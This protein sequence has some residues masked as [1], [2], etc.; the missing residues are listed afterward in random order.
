MRLSPT[1]RAAA[2][3][4]AIAVSALVL[5]TFVALAAA[6]ALAI[7]ILRDARS[8]RLPELRRS[9]PTVLNRG[10]PADLRIEPEPP[11]PALTVRQP[12]PPGIAIEPASGR[13]GLAAQLMPELRGPHRLAPF[14]VRMEG[15]ARLAARYGEPCPPVQVDVY[16]DL[17]SAR[18]LA[19]AV[20]RGRLRDPGLRAL[21]PLGLGTEFES[22]REYAPDDDV[23]RINWRATARLGRPMSNEFRLDQDR[24]VVC[25]VDAGRLMAAPLDV[26]S[27]LDASLDAVSAVALVADELGDRCGGLVFDS[28]IRERIAPRRSGGRGLI[29]ALHATRPS[30]EDSDYELAFRSLPGG[31]RALVLVFSDLID[32][33]AARA[34]IRAVPMLARRHAVA[35]V[36]PLDPDV[37]SAAHEPPTSPAGVYPMVAALEVLAARARATAEL[38]GAGATV[39]EAPASALAGAAVRGYVRS[40]LRATL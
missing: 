4:A 5:P 15:P 7:A 26:R 20:R 25:L 40:K 17:P 12:A 31:K 18:R 27:R 16:P 28:Q 33:I 21:G 22:I 23:R 37:D 1:P 32:E 35:V 30:A 3:L 8:I 2:F 36:T 39:V 29:R 11:E 9:V 10:H 24:D 19:L 14:G 6:L 13:A 34:L 38:R